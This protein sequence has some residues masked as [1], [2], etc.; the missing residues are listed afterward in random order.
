MSESVTAVAASSPADRVALGAMQAALAVARETGEDRPALEI[1]A[2]SLAEMGVRARSTTRSARLLT[3]D[4][5]AWLRRLRSA[6]RSASSLSAY[7]YAIDDLLAWAERT[8]RVDELFEE[9]AIVDYL[10]AYRKRC[11]PAPATYHRRFLLLRR[12]MAWVSQRNGLPDPFSELQA[13]PKPRGEAEWLT[14]EEFARMLDAAAHPKRA[15]P[16]LAER[17]RLVLLTLAM[18]GLRRSELIALDWSD[19]TLD[20]GRPSLLVR[21]GKGG[22]PRRQPLPTE[23]AAGLDRWRGQRGAG[24]SDPVFCGLAGGRLQP[25]LLA[26]IIRRATVR[27]GISK[28]VTAHTLRHTAATWLRQ[29]TGDARLVAE[30]LG[31]AD[32]STVNRYAHV[33]SEELHAATQALADGPSEDRSRLRAA[34][35]GETSGS[36]PSSSPPGDDALRA[37]A[38][39]GRNAPAARI[40]VGDSFRTP[41]PSDSIEIASE[42]P[43]TLS[44]SRTQRLDI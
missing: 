44:L 11:D 16:G 13:P 8:A 26:G 12:F 31:H 39:P 40:V 24:P 9:Q 42:M 25:T 17:D 37:S 19:V 3:R 38:A 2:G 36:T 30:Y 4:R 29:A 1:L 21:R 20:G 18:T 43:A 15:R 35:P 23:L 28:N 34:H 7:R 22:K 33:A 27:A 41:A 6:E 32:L 5:D 10:D 14:R